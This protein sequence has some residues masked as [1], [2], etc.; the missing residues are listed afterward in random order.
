MRSCGSY[1]RP[2]ALNRSP[3]IDPRIAVA[4]PMVA[5]VLCLA[6]GVTPQDLPDTFGTVTL[7]G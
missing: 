6:P 1:E 3:G 4:S 7:D 2:I 5:Y